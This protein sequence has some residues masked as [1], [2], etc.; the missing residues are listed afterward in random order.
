M[1]Q[2]TLPDIL[3]P[4]EIERALEFYAWNMGRELPCNNHAYIMDTFVR[5]NL[6]RIVAALPFDIDPDY[7][8]YVI[9]YCLM[10]ANHKPKRY[11]EQWRGSTPKG[12][13]R[14]I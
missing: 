10:R 9:E 7:I 4:S 14:L 1:K 5:P 2:I 11:R 13:R 3:T 8:G 12:N 6:P